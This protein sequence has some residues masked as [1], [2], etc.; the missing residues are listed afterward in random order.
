MPCFA[1]W[2]N[3]HADC[4][5]RFIILVTEGIHHNIDLILTRRVLLLFRW[6]HDVTRRKGRL[7]TFKYL[8]GI[9]LR[10]G[11]LNR[12][13]VLVLIFNWSGL[14]HLL[15]QVRVFVGSDPVRGLSLLPLRTEQVSLFVK[16]LRCEIKVVDWALPHYFVGFALGTAQIVDELVRLDHRCCLHVVIFFLL[17]TLLRT[18]ASF[19]VE[20]WCLLEILNLPIEQL[21]RNLLLFAVGVL[22]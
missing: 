13:Q 16:V 6:L 19:A 11:W 3:I 8:L 1:C 9:Y 7:V 10:F 14:H 2:L 17:P 21:F 15:W 20:A 12:S 5:E 18:R 4:S 22:L